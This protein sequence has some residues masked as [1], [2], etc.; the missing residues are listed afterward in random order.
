MRILPLSPNN[1]SEMLTLNSELGLRGVVY[2]GSIRRFAPGLF[3]KRWIIV[4]PMG[5][6]I[7]DVTRDHGPEGLDPGRGV[8]LE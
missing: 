8:T 1:P 4:N 6:L 5:L 2:M 3:D 7:S